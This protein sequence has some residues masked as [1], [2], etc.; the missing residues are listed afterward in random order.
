MPVCAASMPWRSARAPR[1]R[2]PERLAQACYRAGVD[3]PTRPGTGRS[4]PVP[5]RRVALIIWSALLI[6]VIL[7]AAVATYVGPKGFWGRNDQLA[8][9]LPPITIGLAV[10]SLVISR[11]VPPRMKGGPA[12]TPDALGVARTIVASGLNEGGALWAVVGWMLTGS[13]MALVALA[14][15]IAGLLLV[16]PSRN[17]WARLCATPGQEPATPL[18][19]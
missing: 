1:P 17:R 7:F 12:G 6:G 2:R 8:A 15:S 9:I 16:F 4:A 19:R 13:T 11:L 10:V 14:I 3:L 5:T 18:V